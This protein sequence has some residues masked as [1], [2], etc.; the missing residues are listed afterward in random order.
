MIARRR[1]FGINTE[2]GNQ[3]KTSGVYSTQ[4][5]IEKWS[6]GDDRTYIHQGSGQFSGDWGNYLGIKTMCFEGVDFKM[7]LDSIGICFIK[8]DYTI[9]DTM[10]AFSVGDYSE[11]NHYPLKTLPVKITTNG[12]LVVDETTDFETTSSIYLE[13][14][15]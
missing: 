12:N 14:I 8:L 9:D 10:I 1:A 7:C 3:M 4:A 11:R 6:D 15:S 2:G 13:K 5:T